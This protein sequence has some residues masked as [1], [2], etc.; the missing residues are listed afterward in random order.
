MSALKQHTLKNGLLIGILFFV[1]YPLGV[2]KIIRLKYP[3]WVQITY[4]ITGF[5]IFI[6]VFT[7]TTIILL[8]VILP[9]LDPTVSSHLDR[10]VWNKEGNYSSTFLK[11]RYETNNAY[12]LLQMDIEPKGGNWWHYHTAFEETF[13]V[14][15]GELA[16]EIGEEK[17]IIK[18]GESVTVPKRN[19]HQFFN[20]TDSVTIVQV[21]ASPAG[22][23]EKTIRI[24]YGL[25]N[26]GELGRDKATASLSTLILMGSYSNTYPPSF[27]PTWIQEPLFDGM[28]KIAQW[29]GED[30]A[31]EAY[32]K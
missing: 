19:L 28:A 17:H 3:R 9:D 29:R 11:S 21:R 13:T 10:T 12:E 14:V 18:E 26:K 8:G 6:V 30:K 32:F 4:A 2:Y 1:L 31:L 23:L 7:L 16:V 27:L 24:A 5:P 15:K 22:G 20:T 25:I